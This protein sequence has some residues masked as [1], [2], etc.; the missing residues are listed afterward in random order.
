MKYPKLLLLMVGAILGLVIPSVANA[1][2]SKPSEPSIFSNFH[3]E[4]KSG[5]ISSKSSRSISSGRSTV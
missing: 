1:K 2:G 3:S 4:P 5:G